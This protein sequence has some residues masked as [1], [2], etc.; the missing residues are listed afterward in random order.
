M[1]T[2][3]N[4]CGA[5]GHT[6]DIYTDIVVSYIPELMCINCIYMAFEGYICFDTYLA[7]MCGVPV[8]W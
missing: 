2:I 7:V 1:T 6:V 4:V 5:P 3:W 8:D